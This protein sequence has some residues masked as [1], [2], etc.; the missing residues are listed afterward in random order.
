MDGEPAPEQRFE[1][2]LDRASL[3]TA[4]KALMVDDLQQVLAT[5]RAAKEA[6]NQT[7]LPNYKTPE[8]PVIH[9]GDIHNEATVPPQSGKKSA[10]NPLLA[11][12]I[13]AGLMAT[14]VGGLTGAWF[15]ADAIKNIKPGEGDG[16]TKYQ[17]QLLP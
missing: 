11:A 13:G 12:A 16:N 17:L 10:M 14:G 2:V 4:R 8:E 7:F 5:N 6:H 1:Q 3:N 9:I 15:I